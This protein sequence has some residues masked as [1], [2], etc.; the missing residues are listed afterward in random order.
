VGTKEKPKDGME[1]VICC[2][3]PPDGFDH[4]YDLVRF[5]L[6]RYGPGSKYIFDAH[7]DHFAVVSGRVPA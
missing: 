1:N 4:K 5:S 7:P 3:Q 6:T 2:T